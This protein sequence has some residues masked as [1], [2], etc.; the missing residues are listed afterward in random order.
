MPPLLGNT[1]GGTRLGGHRLGG[2]HR[3]CPPGAEQGHRDKHGPHLRRARQSEPQKYADADALR[4][5][6]T[7]QH[8]SAVGMVG[9]VAS[10]Q[11]QQHE[12]QKLARP[13]KPRSSGL[14]VSWYTCQ[15]TATPN[16]PRPGKRKIG[17]LRR[18]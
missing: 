8:Q 18:P 14:C 17:P 6:S 9:N 12:R 7:H 16:I 2:G 1:S 11:H 4:A 10:R 3:E 13:T 15:P 5:V